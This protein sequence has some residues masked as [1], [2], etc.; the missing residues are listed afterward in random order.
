MR[1]RQHSENNIHTFHRG[2][3][4]SNGVD[5]MGKRP[6]NCDGSKSKRLRNRKFFRIL[7]KKVP[8]TNNTLQL[9]C[10]EKI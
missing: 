6:G 7:S 5:T 4:V 2:G 3:Y 1:E 9:K 8:S 10:R